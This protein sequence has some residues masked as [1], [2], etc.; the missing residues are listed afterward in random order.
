MRIIR[1]H[2]RWLLLLLL[3]LLQS[4]AATGFCFERS[5][6]TIWPH[7]EL[8]SRRSTSIVAWQKNKSLGWLRSR[9]IVTRI[10]NRFGWFQ[11]WWQLVVLKKNGNSLHH[12]KCDPWNLDFLQACSPPLGH[13]LGFTL[14]SQ[15]V[16]LCNGQYSF[17]VS[18]FSRSGWSGWRKQMVSPESLS[19][20]DC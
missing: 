14:P 10:T 18:G 13:S 1:D 8:L 4:A 7:S 9:R 15:A 11:S 16:A 3:L 19:V 20:F 17:R 12:D 6:E 2:R 5:I